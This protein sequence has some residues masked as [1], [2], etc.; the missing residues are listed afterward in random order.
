MVGSQCH[1][2][3]GTTCPYVP[4]PPGPSSQLKFVTYP[5]ADLR[6]KS[7]LFAR[8][9]KLPTQSRRLTYLD[10]VVGF[11]PHPVREPE[12]VK[13]LQAAALQTV[14]LAT[15][16]LGVP[17]IDNTGFDPAT[18]HPRRCHQ[19]ARRLARQL[20]HLA[21]DASRVESSAALNLPGRTGTNNQSRKIP[22][23]SN[24]SQSCTAGKLGVVLVPGW[25]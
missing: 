15:E 16:N 14:C 20:D 10:H 6:Q 8:C 18:C 23:V 19:P 12:T 25:S 7:A 5:H 21:V 9:I 22:I 4:L 1:C 3:S 11:L 17:L 13:D 2:T 24:V